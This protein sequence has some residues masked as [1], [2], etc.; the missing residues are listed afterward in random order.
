MMVIER[1]QLPPEIG[2]REAERDREAE[3]ERDADRQAMRVIIPGRAVASSP[4]APWTN[5]Q[6]P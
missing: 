3:T 6:P 5:T 1:G 4:T 2:S